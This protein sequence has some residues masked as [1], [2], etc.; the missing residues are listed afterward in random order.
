MTKVLLFTNNKGG[1]GKSTSCANV[2]ASLALDGYRVLLIDADMQM[3]FSLSFFDEDRLLELSKGGANLYTA[4]SEERDLREMIQET[5]TKNVDMI[6]SSSLMS[7]IEMTLFT[8]TMREFVMKRLLAPIRESGTYDFILM[9]AP[10]T[11]GCLVT[12]L[13]LASDGVIIPVEST[14]W[15]LFGLANMFDYV[16]SVQKLDPSLEVLGVLVCKAD[17][18][19]NYFRQTMETLGD[20]SSIHVFDTVIHVDSAI[21]W[22]QDVSKT[23]VEFKKSSRSAREYRQLTKEVEA[24]CR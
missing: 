1:S 24:L 17:E 7:G 15:G 9:D 3:N 14:P 10:P 13:L 12:N 22:A 6:V 21:E 2:G 16:A 8:K 18:R 11:L 4:L 20:L 5:G 19:K 23:V